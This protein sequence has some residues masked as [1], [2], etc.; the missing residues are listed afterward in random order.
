MFV[1]SISNRMDTKYFR[2]CSIRDFSVTQTCVCNAV[3]YKSGRSLR[4]MQLQTYIGLHTSSDKVEVSGSLMSMIARNLDS[5]TLRYIV[6][7]ILDRMSVLEEWVAAALIN[8][9]SI[10]D[11]NKVLRLEN[12]SLVSC[13]SLPDCS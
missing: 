13:L 6:A 9:A 7:C 2:L 3:H 11:F 4:T 5:I 10:H 12:D 8:I 1:L